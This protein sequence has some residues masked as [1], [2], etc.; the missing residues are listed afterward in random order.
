MNLW[1]EDLQFPTEFATQGFTFHPQ[2]VKDG[3]EEV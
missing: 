3:T 1:P 2:S